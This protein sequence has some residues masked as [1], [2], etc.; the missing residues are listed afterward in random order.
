M[1]LA[2]SKAAFGVSASDMAKRLQ[3]E[4]YKTQ[5]LR[6]L[7]MY[8]SKTRLVVHN[9]PASWDD[10][11][12]RTL[13]LRHAGPN[14]II[15]EC[16]IMRDMKRLDSNGVGTSKEF[17]FVTFAKHEDAIKAL[18][19]LNNNPNI[20]SANK[21]PIVSF[22]IENKVMVKAK[23]KRMINSRKKNPM[24]R[25]FDPNALKKDEENIDGKIQRQVGKPNETKKQNEF[26]NRKR[27]HNDNSTRNDNGT[28]NGNE[29]HNDRQTKPKINQP[30]NPNNKSIK[31]HEKFNNQPKPNHENSDI[32]EPDFMGVA[33]KPGVNKMRSRYNLKTQATLHQQQLKE[34]KRKKKKVKKTFEQKFDSMKQPKQM[35]KEKSDRDTFSKMVDRYKNMLSGVSPA[36]KAKWFES[37]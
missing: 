21:R 36:K 11:K 13:M 28:H 25:E 4:Q 22:S 17:G 24:S 35:V 9:L 27:K 29:T 31:K 5:M 10:S 18:R 19:S 33:A 8:I 34:E 14:A 6:N 7:N 23:E 37:A 1:I 26:N 32:S 15:K 20:F 12:F 30:N 16:R 3:I 2:G